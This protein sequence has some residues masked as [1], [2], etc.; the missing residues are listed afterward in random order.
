MGEGE[1]SITG[2][3]K[4]TALADKLVTDAWESSI[5]Q[6]TLSNAELQ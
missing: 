1:A 3:L 4:R 2:V 5:V 6:Q